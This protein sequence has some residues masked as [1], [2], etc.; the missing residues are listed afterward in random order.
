MLLVI[1]MVW[2]GYTLFHFDSF[3]LPN[4][5]VGIS[6]PYEYYQKHIGSLL[7]KYGQEYQLDDVE[8]FNWKTYADNERGF[9][10]KYPE[11]MTAKRVSRNNQG[12]Q[13][14]FMNIDSN[15]AMCEVSLEFSGRGVGKEW[16]PK[17][18]KH[19]EFDAN[20]DNID[21]LWYVHTS[22][23]SVFNIKS[24]RFLP[25]NQN[26]INFTG[27]TFIKKGSGQFL[28]INDYGNTCPENAAKGMFATFRFKQ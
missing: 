16:L 8:T 22:N 10:F 4:Y 25:N 12:Y 28:R 9:E 13:V 5:L 6:S 3:F 26:G 27:M 2:L 15:E 14:S 17:I 7:V 21:E 20:N 1:I 19:T 24:T 11:N 23:D 18:R